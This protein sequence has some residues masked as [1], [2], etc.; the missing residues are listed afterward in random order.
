MRPD[1]DVLLE[2]FERMSLDDKVF[3]DFV[4]DEE[5]AVRVKFQK[6]AKGR[7]WSIWY[8]ANEQASK[9]KV[10]RTHFPA[11][12]RAFGVSNTEFEK[13]LGGMLLT[14]AAYAD[15]FVREVGNLFGSEA[16]QKSILQT[17]EFM[18]TFRSAMQRCVGEDVGQDVAIGPEDIGS[19]TQADLKQRARFR[20]VKN[21]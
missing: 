3:L 13:E 21:P 18:D 2:E 4:S 12:L 17:Q 14:Q 8:I 20:V 11:V 6:C 19:S 5:L 7:C 10:S 16:L 15:E 9:Q 1:M